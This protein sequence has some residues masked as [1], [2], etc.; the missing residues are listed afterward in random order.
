MKPSVEFLKA[1]EDRCKHVLVSDNWLHYV[2]RFGNGL[3]ASVLWGMYNAEI[4]T[5]GAKEGLFEVA[6]VK[7]TGLRYDLTYD[8]FMTDVEGYLSEHEVI[9]LMDKIANLSTTK[10]C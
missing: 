1:F 9:S 8:Y 6:M 7:W 2:Y 3:G 10:G 5:Y 4:G